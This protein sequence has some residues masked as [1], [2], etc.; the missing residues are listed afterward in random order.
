MGVTRSLTANVENAGNI[1]LSQP[2]ATCCII[3]AADDKGLVFTQRLK[4]GS[5]YSRDET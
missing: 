1:D 2:L 3:S 4:M 5:S